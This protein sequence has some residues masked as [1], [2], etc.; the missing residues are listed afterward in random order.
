MN[1]TINSPYLVLCMIGSSFRKDI[2]LQV[3]EGNIRLQKGLSGDKREHQLKT[4]NKKLQFTET[5]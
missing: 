4:F 5:F 1:T 2:L 3:T